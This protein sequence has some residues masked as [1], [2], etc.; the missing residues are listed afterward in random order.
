MKNWWREGLSQSWL[1][2]TTQVLVAVTWRCMEQPMNTII[3]QAFTKDLPVTCLV[4]GQK[5]FHVSPRWPFQHVKVMGLIIYVGLLLPA[6]KALS[7]PFDS[8]DNASQS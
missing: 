4:T 5:R 6:A 1:R 8:Q 7:L 2:N 3:T